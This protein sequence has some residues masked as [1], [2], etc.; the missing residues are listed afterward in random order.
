MNLLVNKTAS[1]NYEILD[2]FE[3]GLQLTGSEVK[4]LRLKHGSL[5]EAYVTI[6]N[7][8]LWL[9]KCH[10][11][12]YQPG[13]VYY[14]NLDTYNSRKLLLHKKQ[15]TS[16]GEKLKQQGL[17][18]IPLRIYLSHNLVKIEIALAKGKKNYDKRNDM[19]DKTAKRE[20]QRTIKNSY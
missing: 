18:I 12:H 3:A 10:I 4:T 5:K 11:P 15:I 20:A 14:E 6:K 17:S 9:I 2:K 7:N 13:H 1:R 19:K 8:E 16:L